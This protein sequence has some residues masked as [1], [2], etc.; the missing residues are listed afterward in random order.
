MQHMAMMSR[1]CEEPFLHEVDDMV[2]GDVDMKFC[3]HMG[4]EIL[5]P[6]FGTL[7][8]GFYWVAREDLS[9]ERRSQSHAH[10]PKDQ[11]DFYHMGA[12]LGGCGGGSPTDLSLSPGEGGQLG[13]WD[14]S[15]VVR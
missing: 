6:L 7:H 8:P 11:G 2:C 1:F 14:R 10:I 12:F 9:Y 15:H 5:P 13:Q 3:D 4:M